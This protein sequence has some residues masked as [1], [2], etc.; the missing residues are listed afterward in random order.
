MDLKTAKLRYSQQ[1][2]HAS[3]RGIEWCFTFDEWVEWWGDDLDNRGVHAWNLQMQRF[4]DKGPYAPWN[5]R[6][7]TPA[8]NMRTAAAVRVTQRCLQNGNE[9][10]A[11]RVKAEMAPSIDL[12]DDDQRELDSMFGVRT[13]TTF[14]I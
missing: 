14:H 5:V 8:M 12:R 10:K 13:V 3:E 4:H 7:G 2:A 1:K 6:K 9:H 11:L